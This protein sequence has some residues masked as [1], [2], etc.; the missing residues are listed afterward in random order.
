MP[1]QTLDDLRELVR[2]QT[3]TSSSELTDAIIDPWLQEAYDRT[4]AV[5]NDWPFFEYAWT[6]T[7]TAGASTIAM[8]TS[9]S[10]SQIVS[11]YDTDE[12]VKP[13]L[14][15]YE[16][17]EQFYSTNYTVS[18]GYPIH[19]SIWNDTITFW[20]TPNF[21]ADH[22][23]RMHGYRLPNDWVEDGASGVPDCDYRFHIYLA[24]Y[25]TALAY[26]QQEDEAMSR[27]YMERWQ[28]G[29]QL[30][31]DSVLD[32]QRQRP[33]IMGP[34]YITPIGRGGA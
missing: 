26:E 3:Q 34:R 18:V 30:A 4:I 22:E 24:H 17:A 8:P 25:A 13:D 32:P 7:L 9:P 10:V 31:A 28:K 16:W 27:L 5:E 21:P 12:D 23:F 2:S 29:V 20:P 6:L 15:P 19:Y 1:Q 33:S 14:V 11:L